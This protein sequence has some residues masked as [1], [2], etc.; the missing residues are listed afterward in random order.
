MLAV[1]GVFAIG[2][3]HFVVS[4]SYRNGRAG[5]FY[6]ATA[7]DSVLPVGEIANTLLAGVELPDEIRSI[8]LTDVISASLGSGGYRVSARTSRGWR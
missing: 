2:N 7:P 5:S 6:A 3:V 4:G 1:E 8:T